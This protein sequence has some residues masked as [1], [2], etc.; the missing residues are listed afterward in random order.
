MKTAVTAQA[1][2]HLRGHRHLAV[3]AA[4][5]IDHTQHPAFAVDVLWA[6]P[7]GFTNTQTAVI[8]K[9]KYCLEPVLAHRSQQLMDSVACEYH[10][11]RLIAPDLELLPQLPIALKR[12][13]V[14]HPQGHDCLVQR[15]RTQL[16]LVAQVDQLIEHQTILKTAIVYFHS[17]EGCLRAVNDKS[18][19]RKAYF[20]S[21][22][23]WLRRGRE[24]GAT[25]RS[26]IRFACAREC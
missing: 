26:G 21:S 15:R 10:Q 19:G 25:A 16:L 13:A 7:H 6:Q 20:E 22:D 14:E 2:D 18:N 8:D 24:G 23:C 12:V 3:P 9:R 4:L 1:L 17:K 5:A 11:Q